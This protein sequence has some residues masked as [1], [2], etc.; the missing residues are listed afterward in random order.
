M[1]A[2]IYA[3]LAILPLGLL[4]F[5]SMFLKNKFKNLNIPVILSAGSLTL[6]AEFLFFNAHYAEAIDHKLWNSVSTVVSYFPLLAGLSVVAVCVAVFSV[7]EMIQFKNKNHFFKLALVFSVLILGIRLNNL[8][9]QNTDVFKTITM[10]AKPDCAEAVL[11]QYSDLD[12]IDYQLAIIANKNVPADLILKLSHSENEMVRFYS[13]FS[14][15]LPV[16]RLIEMKDTD[17]SK[18]VRDQAKNELELNR[19]VKN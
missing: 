6:L 13:A 11:R 5:G 18:E 12:N 19:K 9:H 14:S 4:I 10:L 2:I 7:T 1:I 8:S 3:G 16:P 15:Q 17:A